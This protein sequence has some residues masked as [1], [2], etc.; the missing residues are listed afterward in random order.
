[1]DKFI[2]GLDSQ[3]NRL[4]LDWRKLVAAIPRELIYLRPLR[5]STAFAER[6]CGEE[7]LRSAGLVEQTFA[8]IATNLWDDPF[9]WTLPE[10]LETPEKILEY[11]A[12]VESTRRG[13]FELFKS[14][15][16]LL[17]EIMAP[18]GPTQLLPLL[19]DTLIRAG[20]HQATA[21]ETWQRLRTTELSRLALSA[22]KP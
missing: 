10:T 16:D 11:L 17:K 6:S 14:D 5:D 22:G 7:I 13:G 8:G 3:F 12:E 9:E 20:H 21:R 19:L 4:Y 1:M 2:G 18:S 15:D